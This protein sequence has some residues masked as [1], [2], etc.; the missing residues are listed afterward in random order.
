MV[1]IHGNNQTSNR[2]WMTKIVRTIGGSSTDVFAETEQKAVYAGSSQILLR[3]HYHH[4][5]SPSTTSACT[6]KIQVYQ[7]GA[8]AVTY[9]NGAPSYLTLMEVSV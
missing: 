3:N 2:G 1:G 8:G 7:D 6:Y 5:D 9:Q 4:L